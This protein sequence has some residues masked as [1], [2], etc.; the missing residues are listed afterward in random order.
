MGVRLSAMKAK[1]KESHLDWD[2]ERVD[3][4]YKP[5]EFTMELADEI[6]AAADDE[7]LT[8]VSSMLA[9][10]IVWWDVLD[11]EDQRIDATADNMRRF[12]LNFLL[13]IMGAI[14]EDQ[15]PESEG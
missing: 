5:N 4:A 8:M 11:D 3:F 10:I 15:D 6:Q 1:V 9:P 2:G 12:P 14:T 13:K 7:N